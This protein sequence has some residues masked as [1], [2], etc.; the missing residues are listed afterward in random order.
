MGARDMM[1]KKVGRM[2][3]FTKAIVHVYT[4]EKEITEEEVVTDESLT[5]P[6]S[7]ETLT[8][9]DK[10]FLTGQSPRNHTAITVDPKPQCMSVSKT[11]IVPMNNTPVTKK[12]IRS[13]STPAQLNRSK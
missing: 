13:N 6:P 5:P 8:S 2:V 9:A 7:L 12:L 11:S 3:R 10:D 1:D 4:P